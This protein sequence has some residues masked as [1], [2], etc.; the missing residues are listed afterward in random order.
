MS[1]PDYTFTNIL[2]SVATSTGLLVVSTG[3][4]FLHTLNILSSGTGALELFNATASSTDA[5]FGRFT[6]GVP[7]THTFDATFNTALARGNTTS[8][9]EV[10]LTWA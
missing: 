8:T 10:I 9:A 7:I 4:R 6:V 1:Q 2:G 3:Q 5:L